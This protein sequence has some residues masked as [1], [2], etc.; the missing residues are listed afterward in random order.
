MV[1][2]KELQ[3]IFYSVF[4]GVGEARICRAPGRINLLGEHVDYN[5]L[6]VLPMAIN[7]AIYAAFRPRTDGAVRMRDALGCFAPAEFANEPD[8]PVSPQ[9]AWDNYCKAALQGLNRHLGVKRYP[10]MDMLLQGD[11]PVAAGLSSSSAMVVACALAYLDVLGVVL[12]ED[13]SRVEL[14]NVLADAE[15]YVGTRGGGMDHAAILLSEPG[16]ACRIDFF[17]LRAQPIPLLE[18]Y[19]VVAC[20]S[21]VKVEKSGSAIHRYNE[22]PMASRLICALAEKQAKEEFGDEVCLEHLADLWYGP[23]CLRD[24][25][26][27]GLFELAFPS[28]A[29]TIEEAARRLG[30]S[31]KEVRRKWL[32]DLAEPAE[33]F[34][35]RA[36]ARHQ[37]TEFQ[38]VEAARDLLLAGDA[39]GLGCLLNASHESCA[40]DYMVSCPELDELVS[41]A[42]EGG[43]LGARM[44]GAGFGGCTV[45]L[46]PENAVKDFQ[47]YL[48][49]TYYKERLRDG[50]SPSDAI[51]VVEPSAGAG[52]CSV[53]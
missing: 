7:K 32:G 49:E 29:M 22:G 46:V 45:N 13:I 50:R 11:I 23:L 8:I 44:T 42:R 28:E 38:R 1:S 30:I 33:G 31:I 48:E 9:G 15:C 4:P 21:L 20:N 27:E 24:E 41:R 14:A 3:H 47:A 43:A 40:K 5:G 26:V 52:Y 19:A 34:R 39:E 16:S 36:R 10:G 6:P 35:L 51:L 37:L 18:G 2:L 12:G 53:E 25:E 17:P